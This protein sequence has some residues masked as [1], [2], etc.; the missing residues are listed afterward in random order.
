[1]SGF[2]GG[3][4]F[5]RICRKFSERVAIAKAIEAAIGERRGRNNQKNFSEFHGTQ[6]RNIAAERAGFGNPI[7]YQ[8]A[9]RVVERGTPE[10]VEAMDAGEVSISAAAVIAEQPRAAGLA[11]AGGG[12]WSC[13]PVGGCRAAIV[14]PRERNMVALVVTVP[15]AVHIEINHLALAGTA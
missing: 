6:T 3:D 9:K 4:D 1:L 7:T 8:Q 15:L 14:Q 5:R 2:D 13:E 10:L 12:S 11:A